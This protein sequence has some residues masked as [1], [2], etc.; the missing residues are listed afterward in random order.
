MYEKMKKTFTFGVVLTTILWSVGAAALVPTATMAVDKGDEVECESIVAGNLV[1]THGNTAIWAVNEGL[2]KSYFANGDLFHTWNNDGSYDTHYVYVTNAC[3]ASMTAAG[4]VTPRPGSYILEDPST[5]YIYAVLPGNNIMKISADA[6]AELYG[7]DYATERSMLMDVATWSFYGVSGF[8]ATGEITELVP[9]EGMLVMYSDNYYYVEAGMV[10]RM[11]T[12]SGL[13][14]NG[15]DTAWAYEMTSTDGFTMGDDI[16]VEE[17]ALS[18]VT[19]GLVSTP[20]ED[21]DDPVVIV[22][23]DLAVSLSAMTPETA[24]VP[25]KAS[26]VEYLTFSV[27]AG[28]ENVLIN[29]IDLLRTKLG[30]STNFSKVWLEVDGVPVSNEQ[31]VNTDNTLTLS[32]NTTVAANTTVTYT[33]VASLA[34][35]GA[36]AAK[37]DA[38]KVVAMDANAD[39]TGL[40]VEG[41]YMSY[42]TYEIGDVEITDRGSATDIK[43]GDSDL[44]VG[45]FSLNFTSAHDNDATFN[46]IKL[47]LEGTLNLTDLENLALYSDGVNI[48]S[49]VVISGDYAT[50][51]IAEDNK[52]LAD[53][54]TEKYEVHADVVTGDNAQI[55]YFKLKN[56]KDLSVTDLDVGYGATVTKTDLD[57]T[58]STEG[59]LVT[60]TV[61][62]GQMTVSKDTTSPNAE[63]YAKNTKDLTAL[64]AKVDLG[65][66]VNVEGLQVHV[67]SSAGVLTTATLYADIERVELFVNGVRKSTL[68]TVAGTASSDLY[69]DFETSFSMEDNDLVT[70]VVDLKSAAVNAHKYKFSFGASDFQSPE[71]LNGDSVAGSISGTATGNYVEIQDASVTLTRNDGY[72]TDET[73]VV[74][75]GST[76]TLMKA[77]LNAGNASDLEVR[78][79]NVD[80]AHY[81]QYEYFTNCYV[82]FDGVE[83]GVRDDMSSGGALTFSSISYD[84][85]KNG[86]VAVALMCTLQTGITNNATNTFTFDYSGSTIDDAEGAA[87]TWTD[88]TSAQLKFVTSGSLTVSA[89]SDSKT[90][91]LIVAGQTSALE[92]ATFKASATNGAVD[93]TDIY[94]ANTDGSSATSTSADFL[95]SEYQ[96]V[97]DGEVIASKAPINSKVHFELAEALTVEKDANVNIVV[98]AILNDINSAANTGKEFNM[99]IYAME[100]ISGGSSLTA[101]TNLV[102]TDVD[103]SLASAPKGNEIIVYKAVPTLATVDLSDKKLSSGEEEI[104]KFSLTA[105]GN[106]VSYVNATFAVSGSGAGCSSNIMSCVGATS[107]MKLKDVNGELSTVVFSTST[108]GGVYY[109]HMESPTAITVSE[110]STKSYSLYAT[111]NGFTTEGNDLSIRIADVVSAHV[112]P[113]ASADLTS[114]NYTFVWSDNSGAD[115]TLTEDQWMN[116]YKLTGLETD[117]FTMEK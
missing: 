15:M 116:G 76:I 33:V 70:I 16:E 90:A 26:H 58:S 12:E 3:M 45:E 88:V 89:T 54:R 25:Y 28:G 23:G 81:T 105:D 106:D 51:V 4:A 56:A 91:G 6:A 46:Y 102:V 22:E 69:Y 17:T 77:L 7:A 68:T 18:D 67:T 103:T 43:V 80:A 98:K 63:K 72:T 62:A 71:Y 86:Q 108:S 60:Y 79:L 117:S 114:G 94:L 110:G 111:L 1:K 48:S 35:A 112:A 82:T 95:V 11:V 50:F 19:Q 115:E 73:F 101:I 75:S 9:H 5:D 107:S 84:L 36:S 100:A 64:I 92:L 53:G 42:L 109:I 87:V 30:G 59:T 85:E 20:A 52:T 27:K 93:I 83:K 97:V 8:M 13:S 39:I 66:K 104:Y 14:A 74:G 47:K 44:I 96:L 65:Q 10:L 40:P 37:V 29:S 113:D 49:D 32:P 31:S 34:T 57:G 2:T 24:A 21:G 38:F 61:D 78:T 55:M 99:S 41:N